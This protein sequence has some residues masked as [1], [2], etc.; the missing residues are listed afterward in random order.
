[1]QQAEQQRQT[2]ISLSHE[3][4]LIDSAGHRHR[5]VIRDIS[6]GGFRLE[7]DETLLVGETVRLLTDRDGEY[8]AEI[9][10]ALG[11]EA[12]GSFLSPASAL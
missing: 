2:R 9:R 12:G 1:M 11:R 5:A 3:A 10:W 7:T 4:T 8:A 6:S